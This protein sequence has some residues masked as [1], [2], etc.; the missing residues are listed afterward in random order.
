[1][2]ENKITSAFFFLMLRFILF[3]DS[4]G[5]RIHDKVLAVIFIIKMGA[6]KNFTNFNSFDFCGIDLGK[7]QKALKRLT[8]AY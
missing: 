5:Y 7:V 6:T 3:I 8:G 1:M 2:V 4:A